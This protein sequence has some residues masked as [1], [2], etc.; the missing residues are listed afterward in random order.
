M[1]R[2]P[3]LNLAMH[4]ASCSPTNS[5]VKQDTRFNSLNYQVE[6]QNYHMRSWEVV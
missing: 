4:A 5:S 2:D 3:G 6:G 1:L